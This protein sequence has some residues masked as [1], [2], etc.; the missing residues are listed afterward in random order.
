[1]QSSTPTNPFNVRPTSPIGRVPP[2]SPIGRV[3]LGTNFFDNLGRTFSRTVGPSIFQGVSGAVDTAAGIIAG[4]R[5]IVKNILTQSPHVVRDVVSAGLNQLPVSANL[6]GRYY[7][8]LGSEGLKLPNSFIDNARTLITEQTKTLPSLKQTLQNRDQA[9]SDTLAKA[10]QGDGAYLRFINDELAA[11]RSKLNKINE[12]YIPVD[13]YNSSRS[14]D[15]NPLQSLSTSLGQAYF[16]P[17]SRSGWEDKETYD[18]N[19]AGQDFKPSTDPHNLKS[20]PSKRFSD[21]AAMTLLRQFNASPQESAATDFGRAI[22]SKME[23]DSFNYDIYVPP[24]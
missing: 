24:K 6:F 22:V 21:F 16:K 19:Y 8:G 5:P 7:S 4:T 11:I 2:T 15:N 20:L 3:P 1:M 9:L 18:F 14:S 12:G 10:K 23:P 13:P 17:S